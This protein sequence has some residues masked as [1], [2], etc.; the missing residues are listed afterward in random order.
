MTTMKDSMKPLIALTLLLMLHT[1][2]LPVQNDPVTV[3]SG[4]TL[5]D[6][7]GRVPLQN[8]VV[9]IQGDRIRQVGNATSVSIPQ[10][11]R[12]ID[13]AGKF[14]LPGLIDTHVHLEIVGQSD[15]CELPPEWNAPEKTGQLAAIDARLD[16]IA[17]V[18]TVRDLGSTKALFQLRDEIN[19]G[20]LPG[21]R[22]IA[23][24]MQL[25][26]KSPGAEAEP[27]FLEFDGPDDARGKV[28]SLALLGADVI[29]IRLTR[30]RLIPSIEEVRT[31]VREAHRRGLRATVHTDVPADDLVDLAIEA[32]ADGIEHNAPLRS[33]DSVTL[34][35]LAGK[36]ISLMAGAGAFYIQRIDTTGS[37]D[38]F[39]PP[40]MRLL[41]A[42][43]IAALRGGIDTLNVQTL[44]MKNSG[45]DPAQRQAGFSSEI[46]RAR[47]AG[48][49]LIFGTDCGAYGMM[50]GEQYKALYGESRMGSDPM[51]VLL[52]ATRD[53][54]RALGKSN[55]LG[56]IEAGKLAD[57]IIVNEDPLTDLRHLRKIFRIIKGGVIY[58]PE[59]LMLKPAR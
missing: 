36:G 47:R 4:A 30:Q 58:N 57:L 38:E 2:R 56:T 53:A 40:Q 31:I 32:G 41:P 54:A 48:V 5:I 12:I 16:F 8:A 42:D 55:D 59:E 6:G 44:R 11:A 50:H 1:P 7:T 13:A 25:V 17:G 26:K 39:D 15:I 27:I 52:M 3:I 21:P 10:S 34:A 29:K 23:A 28:G 43:I 45:W 22:I 49:L 24:G 33:R 14:V 37:I 46:E 19:S 35:R 9:I 20:K 51:Q 18:T